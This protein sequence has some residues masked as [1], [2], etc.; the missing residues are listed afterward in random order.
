MYVLFYK[1][2]ERIKLTHGNLSVFTEKL[3]WRYVFY[4]NIPMCAIIGVLVS[5]ALKLEQ[6]NEQ[7][8][9]D[10]L[11]RMKEMDLYGILILGTTLVLGTVSLSVSH[12]LG[13][14]SEN[15]LGLCTH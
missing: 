15:V 13:M 5:F 1:Y 7:R 14:E 3:S 9:I 10:R 12:P 4:M 11:K 2:F 6:P 8:F